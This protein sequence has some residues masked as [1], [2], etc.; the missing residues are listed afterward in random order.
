MKYNV[1]TKNVSYNNLSGRG[2]KVI[3]EAV[4]DSN[5]IKALDISG[6]GIEDRH[7]EYIVDLINVSQQIVNI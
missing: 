4:M 6:N 3:C 5:N 2:T 7:A 1:P